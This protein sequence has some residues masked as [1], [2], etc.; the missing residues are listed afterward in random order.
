MMKSY[1]D[2]VDLLSGSSKDFEKTLGI[3]VRN[4]QTTDA[5][6]KTLAWVLKE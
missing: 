5:V 6:K 2:V 3:K 1:A 4:G